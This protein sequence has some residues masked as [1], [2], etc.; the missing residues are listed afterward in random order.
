MSKREPEQPQHLA[1]LPADEPGDQQTVHEHDFV[2]AE[3]P[4]S[5]LAANISILEGQEPE[6]LHREKDGTLH[7]KDND[8]FPQQL[9]TVSPIDVT[10]GTAYTEKYVKTHY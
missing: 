4:A 2:V 10:E 9:A 3:I 6:D 8:R 1:S 7:I 5:M